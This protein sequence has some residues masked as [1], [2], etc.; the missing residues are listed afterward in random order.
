MNVMKE[1]RIEK[2]TLNIGTGEAGAKLTKAMKLLDTISKLK[3]IATTTKKRI[4]TWG[5]RPG[6]TIGCK[7]TLRKNKEELTKRLLI[8]KENR[9]KKSNFGDGTISFGIPEYIDIP[10]IQYDIDI[11]II[12]LDVS[13]TLQRAGYSIA[14]RATQRRKIGRSHKITKQE[15]MDFMKEKFN[16]VIED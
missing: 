13:I 7:V 11:G 12:G 1:I 2:I 6:L 5:I 4:P 15:T 16:V 8:A 3:S 14:K 10:G 9:L